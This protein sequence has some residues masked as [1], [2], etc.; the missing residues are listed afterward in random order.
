V[1][2][3]AGFTL[4]WA[5]VTPAPSVSRKM[6]RTPFC[7]EVLFLG[8]LFLCHPERSRGTPDLSRRQPTHPQLRI[9]PRCATLELR[10]VLVSFRALQ[11]RSGQ[12]PRRIPD[13]ECAYGCQFFESGQKWRCDAGVFIRMFHVKR[14]LVQENKTRI[15]FDSVERG[16]KVR[17]FAQRAI[18]SARDSEFC[19]AELSFPR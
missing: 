18:F 17:D 16:L 11:L 8:A 14:R 2:P 7:S 9:N 10:S 5:G 19:V 4:P 6:A 15:I 1:K 3:A 13:P 12:A